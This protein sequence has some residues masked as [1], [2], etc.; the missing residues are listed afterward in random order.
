MCSLSRT[1]ANKLINNIFDFILWYALA[2]ILYPKWFWKKLHAGNQA[3][4]LH[5]GIAMVNRNSSWLKVFKNFYKISTP[6]VSFIVIDRLLDKNGKNSVFY[7]KFRR[8]LEESKIQRTLV[9][10]FRVWCKKEKVR[11]DA[12]LKYFRKTCLPV[13]N[14]LAIWS[15][16]SWKK[17]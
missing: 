10:C 3:E 14:S 17:L 9:I 2:T 5:P 13:T 1:L 11:L 12:I 15:Y 8:V 6:S 7:T 4:M 16:Y